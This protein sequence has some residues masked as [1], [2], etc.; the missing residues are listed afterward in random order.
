MVS[1]YRSQGQCWAPHSFMGSSVGRKPDGLQRTRRWSRTK[2]SQQIP[3][4]F[5]EQ[6][7][8]DTKINHENIG[9]TKP[10]DTLV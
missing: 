3:F 7:H 4:T 5:V 2:E 10:A 1:S 6:V 9:K 8:V